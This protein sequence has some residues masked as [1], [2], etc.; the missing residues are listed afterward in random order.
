MKKQFFAT[1]LSVFFVNALATAAPTVS[2]IQTDE[3]AFFAT[4]DGETIETYRSFHSFIREDGEDE[5][6]NVAS[7]SGNFSTYETSYDVQPNWVVNIEYDFTLSY[8]N[9]GNL[10]FFVNGVGMTSPLIY[11]PLDAINQIFIGN[12]NDS[13]VSSNG[14][15]MTNMVFSSGSDVVNLPDLITSST[16]FAGLIVSGFGDTWD[17]SG[18][19]SYTS[20]INLIAHNSNFKFH[21]TAVPEPSAYAVILGLIS[22][23]FVFIKRRR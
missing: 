10:D 3:T 17:L 5:P 19:I 20:D 22:I 16:S 14:M 1:L 12:D 9:A 11:E 6:I 13:G 8:D 4:P 7:G 18:T 2:A 21:G 23:A 15:E